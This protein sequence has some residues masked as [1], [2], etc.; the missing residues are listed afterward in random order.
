MKMVKEMN[1]TEK[2]AWKEVKHA[3]NWV[4]GGHE[5]SVCDGYDE[6]MPS[7]EALV[8]EIYET[9]MTCTT[10]E[11][12]QSMTPC[13][14]VRFAGKQFIMECIEHLMDKGDFQYEVKHKDKAE[15]SAESEAVEAEADEVEKTDAVG[16]KIYWSVVRLKKN[17]KSQPFILMMVTAKNKKHAEDV[18]FATN[19][20]PFQNKVFTEQQIMDA[21]IQW[22]NRVGIQ[23]KEELARLISDAKEGKVTA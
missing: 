3:F 13:D 14:E 10:R 23:D 5:N 7:Y 6:E 11:G 1:G 2:R 19:F 18:M 22:L 15:E 17:I 8:E 12:Y 21:D 20:A 9:V 4:V 16:D